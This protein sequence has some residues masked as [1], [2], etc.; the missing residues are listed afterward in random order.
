MQNEQPRRLVS[1]FF[2][3]TPYSYS[4]SVVKPDFRIKSDVFLG[5]SVLNENLPPDDAQLGEFEVAE[6][7]ALAFE[8]SPA[9]PLRSCW[10]GI[11]ENAVPIPVYNL[12]PRFIEGTFV[13]KRKTIVI[14]VV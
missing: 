7:P 5:S 9:S 6:T 1:V 8:F 13:M 11:E 2:N 10:S 12:Q 4:H 14:K 3:L